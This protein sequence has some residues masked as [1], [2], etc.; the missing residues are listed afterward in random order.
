MNPTLGNKTPVAVTS[1]ARRMHV[2]IAVVVMRCHIH[3]AFHMSTHPPALPPCL[4][5]NVFQISRLN[6]VVFPF[7]CSFEPTASQYL[8]HDKSQSKQRE[9]PC[10]TDDSKDNKRGWLTILGRVNPRTRCSNIFA[11]ARAH[12]HTHTH[13]CTHTCTHIHTHMHTHAHTCT[14]TL[15][16]AHAHPHCTQSERGGHTIRTRTTPPANESGRDGHIT[17]TYQA[18]MPLPEAILM[19]CLSSS[20]STT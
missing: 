4:A 9:R 6:P 17:K 11:R 13:T 16:H 3:T 2:I 18:R 5:T 10:Y 8:W 12:T 19:F 15:T 20:N 1:R 7:S 14:H